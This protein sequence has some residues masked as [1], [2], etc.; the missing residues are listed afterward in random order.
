M[1]LLIG[2][3]LAYLLGVPVVVTALVY[4]AM[5]LVRRQKKLRVLK[6]FAVAFAAWAV[7]LLVFLNRSLDLYLGETPAM[8]VGGA[9]V[10]GCTLAAA[11][12]FGTTGP[13]A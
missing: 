5:K 2:L 7:G 3:M 6:L 9:C 10:F 12:R 1:E 13:A 8:W 4:V 11:L